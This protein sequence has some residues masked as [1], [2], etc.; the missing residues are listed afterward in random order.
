MS[1]M[2]GEYPPHTGQ[3]MAGPGQFGSGQ[4]GPGTS[5][6]EAIQAEVIQPG[7]MVPQTGKQR[8]KTLLWVLGILGG[9]VLL[10]CLGCGGMFAMGYLVVAAPVGAAVQE[11]HRALTIPEVQA[12]I[13]ATEGPTEIAGQRQIEAGNSIE[14]QFSHVGDRGMGTH[15]VR[16]ENQG[17]AWVVTKSV[18][19]FSDHTQIDLKPSAMP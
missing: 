4:F 3:P 19:T 6:Y 5:G 1:Q 9:A 7:P 16:L 11:A 8:D 13:G 18:I 15:T 17:G 14:T 12:R 2:P 10:V